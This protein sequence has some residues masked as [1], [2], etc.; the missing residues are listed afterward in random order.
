MTSMLVTDS[1]IKKAEA[2]GLYFRQD[3]E[4]TLFTQD[5]VEDMDHFKREGMDK[6][7]SLLGIVFDESESTV[8]EISSHAGKLEKYVD[9]LDTCVAH[10][11]PD[12]LQML[13]ILESRL[14]YYKNLAIEKV[15]LEDFSDTCGSDSSDDDFDNE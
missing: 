1:D 3:M 2:N 6:L 12:A 4:H 14:E 15:S 11:M 9:V 13:N 8:D 10:D 7:V 5:D